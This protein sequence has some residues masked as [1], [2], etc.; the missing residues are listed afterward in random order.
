MTVSVVVAT[1]NAERTLRRCLESVRG[2]T[3]PDLEIVVVDNGSE[4]G[5]VAVAHELAD[6]VLLGGS[7]RSAQRNAGA[8]ASSGDVVMFV[9]ADM[10]L[11][12]GVVRD[13]VDR[14]A[15]ADARG[16]VVPERSF[17]DGFWSRCKAL[18][19]QLALGDPAVEAARVFRR[20]DFI[21]TEGYDE[22]L[23]AC[24]DWDLADRIVPDGAPER[25]DASIWHDEGRLRLGTTFSKKRYYGRWVSQWM[26]TAPEHRRRR[27][28][29][30]AWPR[31]WRHPFTAAGLVAMKLV[32]TIGFALG[33]FDA[34]RGR[35][36]EPR[37]RPAD[38]DDVTP[39]SVRRGIAL[40]ALVG[41]TAVQSWFAFGA[42]VSSG[43]NGPWMRT[44]HGVTRSWGDSLAGTGSS[45]YP[46][47][48]LVEAA[49]HDAVTFVGL[50]DTFGQRLW[51]T[52][53]VAGCAAAVAWCA[54][55]FTVRT[56]AVAVAGGA[57][58]LAPFHVT[59][60]PN[61]LPLV[62]VASFALV[63]GLAARLAQGRP[64]AAASAALVAVWVSPLAKNPPLLALF[65]A[66]TVV[67]AVAAVAVRGRGA[68]RPLVASGGWFAAGS[69]FWLVPLVIHYGLGTPGLAIVAQTDVDA[70]SWTQ[71]NS[72]PANV[73]TQVASW[74]WGDPDILPATA[75]LAVAPWT[76]LRWG[77]PL[78]AVAG[79]VLARQRRLAFT[80]G[81]TLAG[82]VVLGVG[83]NAPFAVVNR[84]LLDHV[85]G[86]W[87]FR[88][89]MSKFGVGIVLVEA[90]LAGLAV[91]GLLHRGAT[92]RPNV[93]RGAHA[94]A[95]VAVAAAVAFA[96]PLYT[97]TV[98]PGQ[99][100]GRDALPPA[101]VEVP[102]SWREAG[103][104]LDDAPLDGSVMVL[105]LSEYYQRGTT[106]GYYGV[107]DLLWR[108]TKRRALYLLPGGYY[109]P[110][111]A[112]PELMTAL[113]DA[114]RL[115][116]R[117]G[118]QRLMESLGVAYLA[119]RTDFTRTAG[120]TFA[121]GDELVAAARDN[122]G[123]RPERSFEHVSVFSARRAGGD[124]RGDAR[125][126]APRTL[127]VAADTTDERLADV[128]AAT[129][130]GT[131]LVPDDGRPGAATAWSPSSGEA[132]HVF[133]NV[134]GD[135]LVAARPRSL[136]VWRA[137]GIERDGRHGVT[138]WLGSTMAVDGEQMLDVRPVQ[139]WS[140][141][142]PTALLVGGSLVELGPEPVVFE[143]PG[144]A[145]V[146]LLVDGSPVDVGVAAGEL[147]NCHNTTGASL[148]DA[149]ITMRDAWG[150]VTLEAASGSAC[151]SLPLPVVDSPV[152]VPMW[153]VRGDYDRT[154]GATTRVCVWLPRETACALGTP[155]ATAAPSGSF[156]FVASPARG[157]DADGASLV[158]YADHP[159]GAPP[160]T[161][162]FTSF[163]A[164]PV[165]AA[166]DAAA[167]AALP[168]I[169]TATR[170]V[171]LADGET[172][173]TADAA[174]SLDLLRDVAPN[175][176]D[177]HAYDD[178]PAS[179]TQLAARRLDD[180]GGRSVELRARRHS[181]CVH[182]V[183]E[184]PTNLRHLTVEF[185]HRTV[186]GRVARWCLMGPDSTCVA[187]GPLPREDG[188]T[189]FRRDVTLPVRDRFDRAAAGPLRLYLYADGAGPDVVTNGTTVTQY[190][191]MAVRPTYPIVA[192]AAPVREPGD[193]T[194]VSTGDRSRS[195]DGSGAVV[196]RLDETFSPQWRLD[197]LPAGAS[198]RHV[199]VD[200]WANGWIVDGLDGPRTQISFRYPADL[201]TSIAVWSVAGVVVA[202]VASL[203]HRRSRRGGSVAVLEIVPDAG[204]GA[205]PPDPTPAAD[206]SS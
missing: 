112:S 126:D 157:E 100:G 89:P 19:K 141:T 182:G 165:V 155:G 145:D 151:L 14:L 167:A 190:R 26:R 55:A 113:E 64:V 176:G 74:V 160:A 108:V 143:A 68:L 25:T 194:V 192:V 125:G 3:Y 65:G 137:S 154:S 27:S 178:A 1:R 98:I 181:A 111:G 33:M 50:S 99:R 193:A 196:V 94:V 51:Y 122:D 7:E 198:A 171:H 53:V 61:V 170:T 202:A 116:D 173:F 124:A 161:T 130:A 169:E 88:Q 114:V 147:G 84:A 44:L 191:A 13:A 81:A 185:E 75:T 133:P 87:L 150:G 32:E 37:R 69:L 146:R 60:L 30:A 2:Q 195:I 70:W 31:L 96:H 159:A 180:A 121:D 86:F 83:L 22:T 172:A 168:R 144:G 45:A 187:G 186:S 58:V 128:V 135:H 106:W 29:R 62:A 82:L 34:A 79:V 110:A 123:L 18:E 12:P 139:L 78:L 47:A 16:V 43:D 129:P 6:V 138:I 63:G 148:A 205:T 134:A 11:E 140:A 183:V 203:L 23:V 101:R 142:R 38:V 92:W 175:V 72:G 41:A 102:E 153:R 36:V 57:A 73:V 66:W 136:P 189:E 105:P 8:R 166:D 28:L 85:P 9:D 149:G 164:A 97:G 199:P 117:P 95:A 77:L 91:D 188:W 10:V 54:A 56:A 35:Q 42:F 132:T 206:R 177:C 15:P 103:R 109:E 24:E 174:L 119:I 131:R 162:T 197:G 200:G 118:T 120:R 59:T 90:I 201:A 107:D 76:F 5:T 40:A 158:L 46:S 156:D 152:G 127:D 67:A 80:L 179:R 49:L 52:L 4:D 104:W 184:A 93:R 71:R 39:A 115:G 204:P 163:S 48:G 21:A 20:Q 17:G